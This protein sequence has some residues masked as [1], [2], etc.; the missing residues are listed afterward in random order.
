M[1]SSA[2]TKGQL[3]IIRLPEPARTL[4]DIRG[5][6]P[7]R[8]LLIKPVVAGAGDRVC[9]HGTIITINGWPRVH[10]KMLDTRQRRLPRWHGCL[11]LATSQLFVLSTVPGSFDSR[12]VGPIDRD[13]VIGT[14]MPLLTR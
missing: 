5:Y 13:H 1:K 14:A 6:L 11:L 4:A 7:A 9:R 8:A 10:A 2:P 3:A 12:Y